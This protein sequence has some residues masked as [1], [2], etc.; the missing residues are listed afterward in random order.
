[1]ASEHSMRDC[2]AGAVDAVRRRQRGTGGGH[3]SKAPAQTPPVRQ[4]EAPASPSQSRERPKLTLAPRSDDTTA[5]AAAAAA[6]APSQDAPAPLKK[7]VHA[8]ACF[9]R[10]LAPLQA[11]EESRRNPFDICTGW[12]VI[13]QEACS[14]CTPY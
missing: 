9:L 5:G 6:A 3:I 13:K 1:M 8:C 14:Q 12:V 10:L 7:K 11:W 2:Y 4:A